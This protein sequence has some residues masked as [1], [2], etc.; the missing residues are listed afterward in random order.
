MAIKFFVAGQPLPKARPRVFE[1]R[2]GKRRAITPGTTRDWSA[3]IGWTCRNHL[4]SGD[5]FR[6]AVALSC[7]FARKGKRRADLD[8]MVKAVM[9]GLNGVI[10]VDDSQVTQLTASVIYSQ[11]A[12]GVWITIEYLAPAIKE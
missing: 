1:M 8:N 5:L 10:W 6:G 2:S 7:S 11:S 3:L 4:Y 9:D 12:P